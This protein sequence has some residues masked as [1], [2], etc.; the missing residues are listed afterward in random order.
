MFIWIA[1]NSGAAKSLAVAPQSPTPSVKASKKKD[2]KK[3]PASFVPEGSGGGEF[4]L[5]KC[6]QP[7]IH[8]F[9]KYKA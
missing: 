8:L 9:D 5:R 6:T 1:D 3:Q 2:V 7:N 4:R